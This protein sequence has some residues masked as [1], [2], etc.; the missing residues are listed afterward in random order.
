MLQPVILAG[1]SG[2]RLWPVSLPDHPKP[3]ARLTGERSMLQETV[4]RAA[5]LDEAEE[6]IIIC[7]KHHYPQ[8]AEHLA[9]IGSAGFRAV[10]EPVGRN[11]APAALAAALVAGEDDLL[12][13]LPADHAIEDT[14]AFA[15]AVDR[16]AAAARAGWLVTFGVTPDRPETGYGYIES[17]PPIPDLA[18]VN[19]I[20]SFRE[21]PD[22]ETARR[23]LDSGR[24]S[25]NSGMFLFRAGAFRDE[26]RSASP[27]MYRHVRAALDNESSGG[28]TEL[29]EEAFAACPEGSIDRTVMERTR[30]GAMVRLE[31][32][33]SDLGSWAALW[34]MAT[35]DRRGNAVTGPAEA[36][37]VSS[38]YVAAADRPVLVL[39][40]DGVI[41][42]DTGNGVVVAAMDRAQEVTPPAEPGC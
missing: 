41:V 15:E 40:L 3:L 26:L 5:R 30:R 2:T 25:W 20:A 8:V 31:A 16:A 27:G 18:G 29:E 11:T 6:P 10:L 13:V 14:R 37:S 17:G 42:V 21:K 35:R 19:R 32:G 33:W 4:L 1:G 39:G 24:H 9:E 34:E 12:L 23:F 22:V 28:P 38:S 7:G 36:R